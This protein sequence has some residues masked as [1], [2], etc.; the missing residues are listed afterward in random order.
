MTAAWSTDVV[1]FT[2]DD[3]VVL[4]Q[5]RTG[6]H[7]RLPAEALARFE[8]SAPGSEFLRRRLEAERLWTEGPVEVEDLVVCR[9]RL[10]LLLPDEPA[11]W[12]PVPRIHTAGG[13]G[14]RQ[15]ALSEY[16]VALWRAINDGRTVIGIILRTDVHD[17]LAR[18]FFYR[19]TSPW[20]QAAQLRPQPP[21]ALDPSLARIVGVERPPQERGPD[22][23][24]EWEETTLDTYHREGITDGATH[25]DDRETTVAHVFSDPHPALG[26]SSWGQALHDRLAEEGM[27]PQTAPVVE[28]GC[29]TGRMAGDLR[30][31]AAGAPWR[32][33]RVDLSPELLRTQEANAPDTISVHAD[34]VALPFADAS[35]GLVL[36]NEVIAD[37][38][39]VP[40]TPGDTEGQPGE[41]G[42]RIARY[43]LA[44]LPGRGPY[45]LGAWQFLEEA[46]RVLRPGGF[47]WISEFGD[48]EDTPEEAVHLDH[49]ETSIHFGHLRTVAEALGLRAEVARLDDWMRLDPSARHLWRPHHHSLR[50]LA[51][52]HGTT[53]PARAWTEATLARSLPWPVEGLRFVPISEEG[54]GPLITRFH[55]L[56]A[57][58]SEARPA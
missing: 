17:A 20:V 33:L 43:G 23:R 8:A 52:R 26:G 58:K 4:W 27:L 14:Y 29:G 22:L 36:S 46:A 3:D 42:A 49:P 44:P 55:V 38:S 35:V 21:R 2:I 54:P 34:A 15:I 48:L 41:V 30:R 51:R 53:W 57:H 6:R 10:A 1:R 56:I 45:N 13:R 18:A 24:G 11:L 5:R 39:A 40:W 19:L 16:E 25:F 12:V 28:V 9:N 7:V 37:L 50:A 32:Y 31:R 47:A